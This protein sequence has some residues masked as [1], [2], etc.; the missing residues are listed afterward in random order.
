MAF[1]DSGFETRS[2]LMACIGFLDNGF[3]K[4]EKVAFDGVLVVAISR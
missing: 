4:A 3:V 2:E 1:V